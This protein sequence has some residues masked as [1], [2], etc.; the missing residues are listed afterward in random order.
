MNKVLR[1]SH[2]QKSKDYK[3]RKAEF[4]EEEYER[5]KSE[6]RKF[7]ERRKNIK[8][9]EKQA[10]IERKKKEQAYKLLAIRRAKERRG[11]K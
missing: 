4:E 1:M 11:S 6:L 9:L 8:R 3:E 7:A 2:E 5:V 10:A